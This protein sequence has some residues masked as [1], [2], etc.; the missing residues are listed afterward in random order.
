MSKIF[1]VK[2][3]EKFIKMVRKQITWI[4]LGDFGL[5]LIKNLGERTRRGI[6]TGRDEIIFFL[7]KEPEKLH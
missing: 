6:D 1:G 7:L 2:S 4:K 3:K 5:K